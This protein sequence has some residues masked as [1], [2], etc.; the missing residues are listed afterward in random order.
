MLRGYCPAIIERPSHM[1][2]AVRRQYDQAAER[3]DQRWTG[4][5]R[6]TLDLLEARAEIGPDERVLDLACGTGAFI[7]RLIAKNPHQS[8]VGVDVSTGMLAEARRKLNE[9][10]NVQFL[11]TGAAPLPL[12]SDRFDV[13]VCASALHYFRQTGDVLSEA[14]RVLR[15]GGRMVLLDWDRG[16]WWM[17]ALDAILRVVD[18]AHHRTYTA[19]EIGKMLEDA[20]FVRHHV[21]RHRGGVWGLA[22]AMSVNGF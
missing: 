20:G 21:E 7:G 3:Y 18:S 16:R 4:Y 6:Q 14:R 17:A 15:P 13:V 8:V 11:E 9:A 10:P 12:E 22:L 1:S 19:A 2:R 5:I